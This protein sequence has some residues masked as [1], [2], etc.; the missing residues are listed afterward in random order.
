M[1]EFLNSRSLLWLFS[2]ELLQASVLSVSVVELCVESVNLRLRKSLDSVYIRSLV[3]RSLAQVE[4]KTN[5]TIEV[6]VV[7]IPT[8]A[9]TCHSSIA[10]LVVL[11]DNPAKFN[12]DS[13][14]LAYIELVEKTSAETESIRVVAHRTAE[15]TTKERNEVPNALRVVA[16]DKVAEVEQNLLLSYPILV[17][18]VLTC[19]SVVNLLAPDTLYLSTETDAGSEP[20]TYS[21]SNTGVRTETLQRAM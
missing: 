10:I 16:I 19:G 15:A 3:P 17:T 12:I 1:Y 7:R 18:Y 21:N 11:A 6:V 8:T 4:G 13:D 14:L 9:S 20:L 2:Q 5:F